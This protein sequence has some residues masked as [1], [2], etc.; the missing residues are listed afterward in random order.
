M[1]KRIDFISQIS[2][3]NIDL[4]ISFIKNSLRNKCLEND[5]IRFFPLS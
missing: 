4:L 5:N 1:L 3:K 2:K